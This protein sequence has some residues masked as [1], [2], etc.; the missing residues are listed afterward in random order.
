MPTIHTKKL[1]QYTQDNYK[2][3]HKTTNNTRQL[4]QNTQDK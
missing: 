1:Q 4:Q 2:N 3:T